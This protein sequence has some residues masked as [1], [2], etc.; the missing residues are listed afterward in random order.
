M[1][2]CIRLGGGG[3]G[4]KMLNSKSSVNWCSYEFEF[5]CICLLFYLSDFV[6]LD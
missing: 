5:L 3:V 2:V 4:L 1:C 6:F